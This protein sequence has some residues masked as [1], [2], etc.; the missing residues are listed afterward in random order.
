MRT[1]NTSEQIAILDKIDELNQM[2]I[3]CD[4]Y[5]NY[6]YFH[7][8]L[9]EDIDVQN[10]IQH[11][12]LMK[13]EFEDVSRF[14]KYH[15]DFSTKRRELNQF[16]KELDLNPV[17]MEFKRAEFKLQELLDEV[18]YHTCIEVSENVNIVSDNPFFQ[19]AQ[20]GCATGGSCSCNVV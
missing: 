6:I 20:G 2:I 11:F 3:N 16:K 10:K 8:M 7:N 1:L 4:I 19:M 17:I 5:R 12:S 14:G 18:L 15:P 9:I 13:L